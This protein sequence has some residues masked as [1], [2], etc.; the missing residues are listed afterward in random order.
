VIGFVLLVSGGNEEET[1]QFMIQLMKTSEKYDGLRGL[2]KNG[3]PLLHKY[4]NYFD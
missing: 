2:Y 4:M 1:F 3:F